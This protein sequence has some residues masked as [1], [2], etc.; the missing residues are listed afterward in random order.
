MVKTYS[1]QFFSFLKHSFTINMSVID[2]QFLF[3]K[4]CEEAILLKDTR[5][6]NSYI[7][8]TYLDYQKN[9]SYKGITFSFS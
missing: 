8:L 2:R 3:N 6:C 7:N 5:T 4:P 1:R 9:S